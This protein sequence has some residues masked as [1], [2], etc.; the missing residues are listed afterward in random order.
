[1]GILFFKKFG[2]ALG[3]FVKRNHTNSDH[4]AIVIAGDEFYLIAAEIFAG[5]KQRSKLLFRWRRA[6]V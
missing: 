2:E 4:F 6:R 3:L 1:M 5:F